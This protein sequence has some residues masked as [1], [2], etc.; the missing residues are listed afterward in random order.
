[1]MTVGHLRKILAPLPDDMPIAI[2]VAID[3]TDIDRNSDLVQADL[4]KASVEERCEEV[5]RLYLW[6]DSAV[7]DEAVVTEG[8]TEER[9]T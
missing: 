4:E 8:D 1:M 3:D 9:S 7:D 2:E 6:G 5:E